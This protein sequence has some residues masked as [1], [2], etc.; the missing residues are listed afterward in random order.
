ML[1]GGHTSGPA[2]MELFLLARRIEKGRVRRLFVSSR[3]A[4]GYATREKEQ[5]QQKE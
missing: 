5:R 3:R 4:I 1:F 2:L